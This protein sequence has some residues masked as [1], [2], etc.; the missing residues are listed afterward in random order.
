[1]Q[2]EFAARFIT[3][4]L[5]PGANI[6]AHPDGHWS[7]CIN[8][9]QGEV[10]YEV[11]DGEELPPVYTGQL[12]TPLPGSTEGA[13]RWFDHIH[14]HGKQDTTHK[15]A[16]NLAF[17]QGRDYSYWADPD[18]AGGNFKPDD[19]AADAGQDEQYGGFM[20]GALWVET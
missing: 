7:V 6:P 5:L 11:E 19:A 14:V 20:A 8:R 12:M 17:G 1:M 10:L 3:P 13:L 4:A 16:F 9:T 18:G 15:A 2:Q